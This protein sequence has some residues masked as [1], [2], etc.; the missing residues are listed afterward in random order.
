MLVASR[1]GD[2]FVAIKV[3]KHAGVPVPVFSFRQPS[4]LSHLMLPF[5]LALVS[6]IDPTGIVEVPAPSDQAADS[7]FPDYAWDHWIV[8]QGTDAAAPQHLGWR[9]TRKPDAVGAGPQT[10]VA[11]IVAAKGK[12]AEAQA[13]GRVRVPLRVAGTL[14]ED[15]EADATLEAGASEPVAALP[16]GVDAPGWLTAM[17]AA[18]TA[19]VHSASPGAGRGV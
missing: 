18:V 5:D 12:E 10:F 15:D 13:A 8:C 2:T 17:M 7:W 6:G 11:L 9:F 3:R 1:Q 4:R 19:R 14:R 16:I